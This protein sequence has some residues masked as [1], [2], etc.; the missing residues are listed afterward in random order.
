MNTACL[1]VLDKAGLFAPFVDWLDFST[2]LGLQEDNAELAL[3]DLNQEPYS[4]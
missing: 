4:D 2:V 1:P 3:G